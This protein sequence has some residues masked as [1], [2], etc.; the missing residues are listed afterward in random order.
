MKITLLDITQ[1]ATDLIESIGRIC[2]DSK[3][4]PNYIKGTIVKNLIKNGHTSVLEHGKATFK[5]EGV[6]RSLTH[7]LVRHRL[8]S[9]TQRSQRYCKEDN[10]GYV[11]P[12][13]LLDDKYLNSKAKEIFDKAM[14]D[15]TNSYNSLIEAGLK[16]EDARSVL[17]N[18]CFTTIVMTA[19]FR[20]WRSV[21]E[22]RCEKH[23]QKEIRN[24]CNLILKCLY[25]HEPSIFEDQIDKFGLKS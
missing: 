12:D 14:I 22:L 9:Y 20:E 5:I 13:S 4:S 21:F 2:Y 19:N 3:A 8:A 16:P 1:N 17:P 25:E 24:L 11:V 6:S 7:Q 15:A 23:A 18:A 10:F